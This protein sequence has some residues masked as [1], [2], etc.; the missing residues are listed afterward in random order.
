M[1]DGIER[2]GRRR[3]GDKPCPHFPD[4]VGC[5]LIGT[6][7]GRQLERK[8]RMVREALAAH[9]ALAGLDVPPPIGSP[10]AFGYRNQAKLVARR[11]GRGLLLG[12]YRPGTHQ[13]VD[14]GECPVHDPAIARVLASA[15][16]ILEARQ[17]PTYD[18][19][20]G[21]G[22]LRY[23]VVR[24]S[25]WQRSAQ[26]ILVVPDRSFAGEK[27][28]VRD[29]ARLRG[30]TSVVLGL[31]PSP[32]NAIFG[33]RFVAAAGKDALIERIGD[34][35]IKTRAGV[36]LQANVGVARRIYDRV[37]RWAE[38]QAGETCID[39]YC[40]VGALTFHLAARAARVFGIE[41]SP[42]AVLDAKENIRLNG[43]HNVRFLAGPTAARLPDLAQRLERVDLVT[44]NPP[45]K[46]ADEPTRLA[47]VA[48]RP[49]RL[50]Y[51]SCDPSTLARDLAWLAAHGY[52]T[53]AVQPFDLLPQ[54][55]HVECVALLRAR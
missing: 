52:A 42:L 22:W 50:V 9:P 17:V 47:V 31:N 12:I 48:C 29:L 44:L 10:K 25:G 19:R 30:V 1:N 20:T 27:S 32:G 36:F 37:V 55:E 21:Q 11:S 4:C 43:F 6:P 53:E 33:D 8:H 45:R 35:R 41:E 54:T 39:L 51:V 38:P 23:L 15:R 14:I 3:R 34:L 49:S 13:V 46:G 7:Y 40:G 24:A 26:V 28:V 18:E 16:R 2:P 5:A